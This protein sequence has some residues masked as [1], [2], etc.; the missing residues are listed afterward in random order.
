MWSPLSRSS[1]PRFPAVAVVLA[2]VLLFAP[3]DAAV[4][5]TDQPSRAPKPTT[6]SLSAPA[7]AV[8]GELVEIAG[9]LKRVQLAK[10]IAGQTV[11]VQT[12]PTGGSQWSRAGRTRTDQAG[13]YSLGVV[14]NK[15]TDLRARFGGTRQLA[16]RTSKVSRVLVDQYISVSD[17]GPVIVDAGEPVW[18]KG[19]TSPGLRGER[20]VLEQQQPSGGWRSVA[21]GTVGN[22]A[23]FRVSGTTPVGGFEMPFRV[24]AP[25]SPRIRG[26]A[27][28]ATLFTVYAWYSLSRMSPLTSPEED[29]RTVN[30]KVSANNRVDGVS[31]PDSWTSLYRANGFDKFEFGRG[32]FAPHT[33][34]STLEATLGVD[35]AAGA[36]ASW[37]FLFYED[38]NEFNL[39]YIDRGQTQRLVRDVT[40]VN[41]FRLVNKRK[42]G[43]PD[44]ASYA[45]NAVWAGAR[46]K[47]AG[48]P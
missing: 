8:S 47:C 17:H 27:S 38:G 43:A 12:R 1:F 3:A 40:A 44:D 32:A 2:A 21:T 19:T 14:V 48:A 29:A 36:N 4:E 24:S 26:T 20:V 25:S 35:D 42:V 30:F 34:C 6:L 31:Y 9:T 39:G 7:S 11:E 37:Q 45:G 18:L 10:P 22:D 33:E 15:N 46:I 23:A 5:T 28:E 16:A 13:R 41:R